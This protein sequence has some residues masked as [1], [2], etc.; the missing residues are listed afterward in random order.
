MISL[1]KTRARPLLMLA[2]S[3][4]EIARHADIED[5]RP[6]GHDVDVVLAH[7]KKSLRGDLSTPQT[8]LKM[9]EKIK[10]ENRKNGNALYSESW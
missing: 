8:P 10:K 6:I 2:R 1:R 9:T 3:V 4:L 5:V 7:R